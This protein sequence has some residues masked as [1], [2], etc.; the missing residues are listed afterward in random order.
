MQNG[1][2]QEQLY[3]NLNLKGP[4]LPLLGRPISK[5]LA[6]DAID[7]YYSLS[8]KSPGGNFSE[9]I[10]HAL[11]ISTQ[12][13]RKDLDRIPS[14]GAAILVAN[15]PFGGIE[16][17]LLSAILERIRPDVK[18]MANFIL[19]S[20]PELKDRF[21]FVDPFAS[22]DSAKKNIGPMREAIRWVKNGGLLAV[23]P[24]GTVSHY[25]FK[26]KSVV[27]PEWKENIGKLIE[28]VQAPVIPVFFEGKNKL[29]FQTLGLLHPRLRTARLPY[30]FVNK[31]NQT[32]RV[33]VGK[34]T[35]YTRLKHYESTAEKLL[36]LRKRTYNLANRIK[37]QA[38]SHNETTAVNLPIAQVGKYVNPENEIDQI[39]AQQV[40][41]EQKDA[42]VFFAHQPQIPLLMQEIGRQR[43][44]AFRAVG[45]GS[46]KPLDID[47]YD[48]YYLHL[49][50]WDKKEKHIIGA[51]RLGLTD[52]IMH[53]FGPSG[54]YTTSLFKIKNDYFKSISP[55]I[56]LGRSFI[57]KK[58]Q[59]SFS[60]LFLL[61]RGIGAFIST[62]PHYRYL[63][64]PVSISN[65]YQPFSQTMMVNYLKTE[66]GDPH[67]S[68]MVSPKNPDSPGHKKH[69][70]SSQDISYL[71]ELEDMIADLEDEFSGVPILIRQYLK[72][73]AKFVGFNRDENFN[74]V[75]DGLIVVDL[76]KSEP[77]LILKYLGTAGAKLFKQYHALRNNL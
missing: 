36:Y 33:A 8:K 71:T 55:A 41:F 2:F 32:F 64:G 52:Q 1:V 39:P 37:K 70:I 22:A 54:L 6:I 12:I 60:S 35:P 11:N 47:D 58:Y 16:G 45:E 40:L 73:G 15:H 19:K 17:V 57:S 77:K 66:H 30:E 28:R 4:L 9:Q 61:W 38:G 18:I 13:S 62:H 46:G 44:I 49:I 20:I 63:F 7:N 53:E 25:N 68:K 34:A 43:E 69:S 72:L 26:E 5:I 24:S 48:T 67:I 74:S 29:A 56:E 3:S 14:Q 27:D 21:I 42:L 51:Y 59:R 10:L 50:A 65:A 23:F 75:L 31:A 76:C